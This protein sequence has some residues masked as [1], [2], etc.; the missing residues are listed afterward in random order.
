MLNKLK[1]ALQSSKGRSEP[2]A[3]ARLINAFAELS[4]GDKADL[5]SIQAI[6]GL[7]E[8]SDIGSLAVRGGHR[9]GT[10]LY[11]VVGTTLYSINSSGTESSIGNI[12]GT[13]PVR[14]ADNGTELAIHDGGTT[15]YVYSGGVLATPVDLPSVSDVAFMDGYFIWTIASSDQFI[16]S[17]LDDGTSYD[18][19]DVATAEG[20]PDNLTGLVN[21]HR[22]LLLFG[23]ATG[24]TPSTEIYTDTGASDFPF[25]RSGNAF[26]ERGCIDRDSMV[27]VDNATWFV[28]DD[29]IVYRM[30]GYTPERM[31]THAVEKTLAS[32]S[33]FRGLTYTQEGHKFYV[34]N[35]DAGSWACDIATSNAWHE[36]QSFG[37]DYYRVGCSVEAY[38]KTLFGDNQTGKF[39]EPDLDVVSE[40][41][42][43]MPVTIELPPLGD[44]VSRQT[45][46]VFELFM[47]TG[48]G[49]LTTTDPQVIL[50][51]SKNGGRAWSTEMWRD[52]GAQGEYS[53]RAVWRVNVEFRQLQ[54]RIVLPDKVRRCVIGYFADVR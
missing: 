52:L 41:G 9:M 32:A 13:N 11:A 29:R 28:G 20:S 40:N 3:G 19:L 1:P 38:G 48:V 46:Y 8:F 53:T 2:W 35:T 42:V 47:E 49:D 7:T 43:A 26:I 5:Y 37:L 23:G 34:L 36:R 10:V 50:T 18:P 16:I 15:G 21:D 30:N 12:P 14:M 17:G 31:S 54:L 6:P 39:Y 4:E 45:L 51:Y 25:E 33:W 22:E 24:A 27:K 44:G